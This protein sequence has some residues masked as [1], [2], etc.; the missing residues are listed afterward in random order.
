MGMALGKAFFFSQGILQ[1]NDMAMV[2]PLALRAAR[3]IRSSFLKEVWV[4]H[5]SIHHRNQ[6]T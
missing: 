6:L 3:G 5:H 4:V 2:P 1:E